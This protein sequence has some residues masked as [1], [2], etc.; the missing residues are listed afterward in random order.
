MLWNTAQLISTLSERACGYICRLLYDVKCSK[1]VKLFIL[2]EIG[3]TEAALK[4]LTENEIIKITFPKNADVKKKRSG[5]MILVS[6]LVFAI[7]MLV[8][9]K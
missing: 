3:I 6:T 4:K 8:L 2:I 7:V 1:L 9:R 5:E